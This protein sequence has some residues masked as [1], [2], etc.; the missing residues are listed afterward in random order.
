MVYSL[1]L[2]LGFPGVRLAKL[3]FQSRTGGGLGRVVG[4]TDGIE[5]STKDDAQTQGD[6]DFQEMIHLNPFLRASPGPIQSVTGCKAVF[7]LHA[8]GCQ[9]AAGG[10]WNQ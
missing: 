10:V 2:W 3:L 5:T 7:C 4:C 8:N 9:T 1:P 6:S